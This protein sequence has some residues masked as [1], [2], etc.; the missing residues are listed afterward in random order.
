MNASCP[1][2]NRNYIWR[3]LSNLGEGSDCLWQGLGL[4]EVA[5]IAMRGLIPSSD[6]TATVTSH[7]ALCVVT[8]LI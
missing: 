7:A 6:L 5:G 3:I 1:R 2:V 8:S 4:P